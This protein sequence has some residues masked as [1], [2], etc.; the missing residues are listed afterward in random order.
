MTTQWNEFG[1]LIKD[2][3]IKLGLSQRSLAKAI[4]KDATTIWRWEKGERRPKQVALRELSAILGIKIQVLQSKSGYT[5]E[6]D[7]YAS[8]SAEPGSQDDIL[9]NVSEEEKESLRQY[10]HF[11][12]FSERVRIPQ[13]SIS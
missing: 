3:R 5:P 7:W 11:L 8:L 1:A 13:K 9:M 6:F 10:L 2:A 12:R 4:K